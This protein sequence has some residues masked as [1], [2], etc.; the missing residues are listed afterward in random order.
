LTT[1]VGLRSQEYLHH[2]FWKLPLLM[3]LGY[4]TISVLFEQGGL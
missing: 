1:G 2:W 3:L 4:M